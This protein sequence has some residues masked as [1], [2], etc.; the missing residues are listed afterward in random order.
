MVT[1]GSKGGGT[2]ERV[3]RHVN[4]GSLAQARGRAGTSDLKD[5]KEKK[6]C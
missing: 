3:D 4:A 1:P 5:L 6:R 2:L